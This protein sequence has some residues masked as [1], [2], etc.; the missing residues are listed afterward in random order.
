MNTFDTLLPDIPTP[1]PD[2]GSCPVPT[3]ES[4]GHIF[5]G[6]DVGMGVLSFLHWPS[7]Q[8]YLCMWSYFFN[9][10]LSD[11]HLI[12]WGFLG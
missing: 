7:G 6:L 9:S 10:F 1:S 2:C 12:V 4:G 5:T 8:L 11:E 3:R